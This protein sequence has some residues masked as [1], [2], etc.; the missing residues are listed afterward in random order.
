MMLESIDILFGVLYHVG[1]R[2][3]LG[4][5]Y[6]HVPTMSFLFF[7]FEKLRDMAGT[8]IFYFILVSILNVYLVVL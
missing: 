4:H 2:T 1:L 8:L 6:K 7:F 3:C 5:F